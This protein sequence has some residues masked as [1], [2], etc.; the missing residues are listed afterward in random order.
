MKK[1][2]V[3][4]IGMGKTG[5]TAL[6][7]FFWANRRELRRVGILYPEYA[8]QSHAHH[9]ISPYIPPD[10]ENE[11]KF[12]DVA[13]WA[14]KLEQSGLDTILLSSELIAWAAR[15]DVIE[16]C[17]AIDKWFDLTVTLYLRRQD[18]M[19][20]ANYNQ[21]VKSGTQLLELDWVLENGPVQFDYQRI[22]EPWI[23]A[24]GM[25]N[26]IV[27]PYEKGQFYQADIR[28]DF[29]HHVFGLDK[30]EGFVTP[31]GNP[32]PRF[33]T[34]AMSYKLQL[35]KLFENPA[36]SSKFNSLLLAFSAES[37]ANASNVY[38]SQSLLSPA[39]RRGILE[40]S[41]AGNEEIARGLMGRDDG[42]LFLESV[43]DETIPWVKP[44]LTDT[45]ARIITR[46]IQAADK[47]AYQLLVSDVRRGVAS[48]SAVRREAACYL[49]RFLPPSDLVQTVEHSGL[50]KKLLSTYLLSRRERDGAPL[51][52]ISVHF[53]GV[54]V[55]GYQALLEHHFGEQFLRD[56][57]DRPMRISAFQR[58]VD[59]L[60]N[61]ARLP[62]L[63]A[64]VQTDTC[65][66]G[67]FLPLK[68]RLISSRFRKRFV[69]W[70]RDPVERL[71]GLYLHWKNSGTS[72][73]VGSLYYRMLEEGWS[74]ETF[75][76][77]PEIQNIYSKFLWGFSLSR[78]DFIGICECYDTEIQRFSTEILGRPLPGEWVHS[79]PIGSNYRSTL[80]PELIS[81]IE[82]HHSVDMALYRKALR[83]RAETTQ[84]SQ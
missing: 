14:P 81:A 30:L 51:L 32:N 63:A 15:N 41:S 2:L 1:H 7:E 17:K 83:I 82:R 65:L 75:C 46:Y 68:Y 64:E 69:T 22:L 59:A 25:D 47:Q 79:G 72:P 58:N 60:G 37:D 19:I 6:Q 70:M 34:A 26:I 12:Q 21:L 5:T 20:M 10:L 54:D 8:M 80:A 52:L 66:H 24:L 48:L 71:V 76:F 36:K 40:R 62:G 43:P 18:N 44:V 77:Q 4:H 35:N 31:S 56:Y 57:E 45:E 55:A 67:H 49:R 42:A 39:A 78:F 33:S 50:A 13:Q 27:R 11:W 23:S 9:L 16:F 28:R 74:L 29:M 84:A 61:C 3:L 38:S 73:G 53:P